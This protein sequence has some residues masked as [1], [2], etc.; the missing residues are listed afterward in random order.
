M[1]GS[2]PSAQCLVAEG[3]VPWVLQCLWGTQGPGVP[4][5]EAERFLNPLS[6]GSKPPPYLLKIKL[7]HFDEHV[8]ESSNQ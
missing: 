1:C 7:G 2:V 4:L 8:L 3:S 6:F 5:K